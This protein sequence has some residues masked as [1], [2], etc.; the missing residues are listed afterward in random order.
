MRLCALLPEIESSNEFPK[1]SNSP[2]LDY[3]TLTVYRKDFGSNIDFG[4]NG[5]KNLT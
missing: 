1:I 4:K 3:T 5:E 2:I